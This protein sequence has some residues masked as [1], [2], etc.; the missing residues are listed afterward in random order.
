MTINEYIQA[1]AM[2]LVNQKDE[3]LAIAGVHEGIMWLLGT[4][5]ME[6]NKVAFMRWSK[7]CMLPQLLKVNKYM[8]NIT[9]KVN[10]LH[11]KWLKWLGCIVLEENDDFVLFAFDQSSLKDG[12]NNV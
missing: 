11:Y 6:T 4:T 1:G 7:T 12:E 9:W 2:A 5:L 10:S 3:V 8:F